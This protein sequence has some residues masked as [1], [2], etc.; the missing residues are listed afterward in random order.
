MHSRAAERARAQTCQPALEQ[1]G[2]HASRAQS[3]QRNRNREKREVIEE[4]DGKQA[5]QRQ[6]QQQGGE[7]GEREARQQSSFPGFQ[8]VLEVGVGVGVMTAIIG[9]EATV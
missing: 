5:R 7:A 4:D 3:E 2:E 9:F 6:F 8:C 1:V